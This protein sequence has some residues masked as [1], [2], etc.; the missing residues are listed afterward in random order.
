MTSKSNA[1]TYSGRS[2]MAGGGE[3]HGQEQPMSFATM[4][5]HVDA[6][7]DSEQRVQ[8]ALGLADR[9]QATLIGV[10]GLALQPSFSGGPLAVYSDPTPADLQRMKARL[11]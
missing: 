5:V 2:T 4:M 6:G 3:G 8:L 9:F 1:W 11:E 7:R 10:A